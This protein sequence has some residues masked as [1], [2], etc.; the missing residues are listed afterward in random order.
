MPNLSYQ[1]TVCHP[2]QDLHPGNTFLPI[3][4]FN[5]GKCESMPGG[6]AW[7]GPVCLISLYLL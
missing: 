2:E 7:R 5:M 3:P 1:E 6:D 4:G